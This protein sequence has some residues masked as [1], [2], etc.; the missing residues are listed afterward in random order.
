MDPM[1]LRRRVLKTKIGRRLLI[2]FLLSSLLPLLALGWIAIRRAKA[3]IHT[4]TL[5]VLQALQTGGFC[6]ADWKPGQ[7]TL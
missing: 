1:K 4:Q 6:P 5:R 7:Q 3:E 2:V